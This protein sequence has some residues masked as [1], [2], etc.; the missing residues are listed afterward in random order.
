MGQRDGEQLP[1]AVVS[2]HASAVTHPAPQDATSGES[3]PPAEAQLLAP[4]FVVL[5]EVHEEAAVAA[6][7][8]LL[9]IAV[10]Q[11]RARW[12]DLPDPPANAG[13]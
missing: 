12:F 7:A 4:S 9:L 5:D 10:E 6:L 2:E 11:S 8:E 3:R 13:C 1:P